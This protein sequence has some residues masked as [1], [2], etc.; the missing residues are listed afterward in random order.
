MLPLLLASSVDLLILKPLV[1]RF[2]FLQWASESLLT[3][4]SR[5]L[6]Q[7]IFPDVKLCLTPRFLVVE[8][9]MFIFFLQLRAML[10]IVLHLFSGFK[11][12]SSKTEHPEAEVGSVQ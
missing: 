11:E 2:T 12:S 8:E 3:V 4:R 1:F 10:L 9:S 7:L 6:F 5:C